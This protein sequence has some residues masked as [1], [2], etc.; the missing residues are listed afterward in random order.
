[1]EVNGGEK[2]RQQAQEWREGR[3]KG[4][5]GERTSAEINFWLWRC[6]KLWIGFSLNG[7]ISLCIDSFVFVCVY[8]VFLS[9]AVTLSNHVCC[10]IVSTVGGGGPDGI[11]VFLQCFDT[12]VWVI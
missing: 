11:E 6:H 1:M 3:G 8:F 10:I 12:V 5:R 2:G 4:R 9:T 7:P